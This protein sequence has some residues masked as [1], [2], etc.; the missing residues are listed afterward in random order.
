MKWVFWVFVTNSIPTA[1]C[2][3]VFLELLVENIKQHVNVQ[4]VSL[5]FGTGYFAINGILL[6][7]SYFAVSI[8]VSLNKHFCYNA[9][10]GAVL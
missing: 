1:N 6:L 3:K 8:Y 2:K 5:L 10:S 9:C 4:I 7:A